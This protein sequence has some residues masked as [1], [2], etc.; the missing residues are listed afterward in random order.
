MNS[1]GL[2]HLYES[3][4]NCVIILSCVVLSLSI[5]GWHKIVKRKYSVKQIILL[6]LLLE[7]MFLVLCSTVFYRTSSFFVHYNLMPFWS[8][9]KTF[10]GR[11]ELVSEII[12]NIILGIPIGFFLKLIFI[13]CRIWLSIIIGGLL[14]VI[15]EALQ[16]FLKR[17]YCELDD[18]LN[19]ILGCIIGYTF[20][21]ILKNSKV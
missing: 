20:G 1:L 4:P 19:N 6:F 14:S 11:S 13:N 2:E 3:I 8:Y 21:L 15:I 7:Y 18:V 5:F 9:V 10:N 16:L 12:C 17:G